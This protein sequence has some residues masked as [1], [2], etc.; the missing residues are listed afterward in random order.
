M[1]VGG[2]QSQCGE[3]GWRHLLGSKLCVWVPLASEQEIE[4]VGVVPLGDD[5]FN[6]VAA[7]EESTCGTVDVADRSLGANDAGEARAEWLLDDLLVTHRRGR[8]ST[9]SSARRKITDPSS[10]TKTD[11]VKP[12]GSP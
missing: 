10:A 9:N 12:P 8:L 6:R 1:G 7:V 4:D 11:P 3:N 2:E 5:L